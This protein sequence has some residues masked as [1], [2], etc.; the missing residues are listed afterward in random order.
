MGRYTGN[1][2]RL[3][4]MICLT[5][6]FFF[7]EITVG[8]MT[9]SLALISDSYHML[10]D[11]VALL[12]GFA[13]IRVAQWHSSQNTYGWVRAEVLGAFVNAVFLTA[14]CFTIF[15]EAL[16]RLATAS[17]VSDPDLLFIIGGIGLFVN[18]IGLCL[19]SGIDHGHG[20]SHG[21]GEGLTKP[22]KVHYDNMTISVDSRGII[23]DSQDKNERTDDSGDDVKKLAK[24]DSSAKLNMRGVFLHV[25]G[26]AL[27]SVIVIVSAIVIKFAEGDW[28]YKFDP[29]MRY[30]WLENIEENTELNLVEKEETG[31]GENEE[32]RSGENEESRSGEN[33]E[34]RSGENEKNISGENK[35]SRSGENE[36]SRSD[37]NEKNISGGNMESR[38]GEN[39]ESR[40]GENEKN[41]SGENKES[42]G[43]VRE[44]AGK[45][46]K[47]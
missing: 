6:T 2:C 7:V 1:A 41:I 33:E 8:Y 46:K 21:G 38:S 15:I 19:F 43:N 9:N 39:E 47:D 17:E 23:T 36:E 35:E 25:L 12:V 32:S 45:K 27:G 42:R 4:C 18:L 10:S 31:S 24:M 44:T 16:Q 11:V 14:L 28:K 3:L 13:S 30:F 20:H 22:N 37:E 5:S 29:V 40:S 34:S 26:D